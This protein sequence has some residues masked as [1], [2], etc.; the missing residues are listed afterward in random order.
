MIKSKETV[1]QMADIL[2]VIATIITTFFE[3]K[4]GLTFGQS[5]YFVYLCHTH[6][7]YKV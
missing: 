7:I 4:N 6:N 3:Q 2:Q 1:H 5:D